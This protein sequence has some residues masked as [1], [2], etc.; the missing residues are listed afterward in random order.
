MLCK[1]LLHGGGRQHQRPH[2]AVRQALGRLRAGQLCAL[3][4]LHEVGKKRAHAPAVIFFARAL[5]ALQPHKAEQRVA[6]IRLIPRRKLQLRARVR[7]EAVDRIADFFHTPS[8]SDSVILCFSYISRN[9]TKR[10]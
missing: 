8:R 10:R 7:N 5:I 1:A 2:H 6:H 3:A 9:M 4:R